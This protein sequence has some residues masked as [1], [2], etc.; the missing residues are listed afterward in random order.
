[1]TRQD[2]TRQEEVKSSTQDKTIDKARQDTPGE[3]KTRQDMTR[4]DKNMTRQDK[5]RPEAEWQGLSSHNR[6]AGTYRKWRHVPRADS[7]TG[8]KMRGVGMRI[9]VRVRARVRKNQAR[10]LIED[11]TRHRL[12]TRRDRT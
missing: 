2:K 8:F 9:G 12:K 6:A 3:D 4:Q 1:M 10:L 7:R 11:K 5:T